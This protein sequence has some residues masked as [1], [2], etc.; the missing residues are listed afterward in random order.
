MA[1]ALSSHRAATYVGALAGSIICRYVVGKASYF[2][3]LVRYFRSR[4]AALLRYHAGSDFES[5]PLGQLTYLTGRLQKTGL[6]ESLDRDR[7]WCFVDRDNWGELPDLQ[8]LTLAEICYHI[9]VKSHGGDFVGY[10]AV[11]SFHPGPDSETTPELLNAYVP[12]EGIVPA[13][14]LLFDDEDGQP[15]TS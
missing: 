5:W 13:T 10:L 3:G 12:G 6:I 4:P 8:K 7:F 9:C 14:H 1:K 2:A 15:K 11:H